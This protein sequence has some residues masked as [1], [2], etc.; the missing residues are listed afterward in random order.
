MARI[1]GRDFCHE[2]KRDQPESDERE[3]AEPEKVPDKYGGH[4]ELWEPAIPTGVKQAAGDD[5]DQPDHLRAHE[6]PERDAPPFAIEQPR[7]Q[8]PPDGVEREHR[9]DDG[10]NETH[11]LNLAGPSVVVC[12]KHGVSE[13]LSA[14]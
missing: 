9:S 5:P 8:P 10:E 14:D 7:Q 3:Q 4:G 11:A 13:R 2:Q 1:A 6:Y 12:P